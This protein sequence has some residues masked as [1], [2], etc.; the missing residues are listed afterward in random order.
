MCLSPVRIWRTARLSISDTFV[1]L[2]EGRWRNLLSLLDFWAF[3]VSFESSSARFFALT[4]VF[5]R[6]RTFFCAYA[7]FL[8]VA[9][10]F[11]H[12]VHVFWQAEMLIK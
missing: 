2:I 12:Y 1:T 7:R 10:V 8:Y 9:H 4:H 11:L 3:E 5:L 6:L